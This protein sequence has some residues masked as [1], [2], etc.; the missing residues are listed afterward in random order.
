M[1]NSANPTKNFFTAYRSNNYDT[2]HRFSYGERNFYLRNKLKEDGFI[3]PDGSLRFEFFVK[4][5]NYRQRL[6]TAKVENEAQ[7]TEIE[8]LKKK[9]GS[10]KDENDALKA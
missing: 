5:L 4:K 7:R 10:Q 8:D 1:I 9:I 2:S 6:E 3:F